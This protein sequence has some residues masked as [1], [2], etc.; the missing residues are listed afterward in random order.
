MTER[1]ERG[2][3]QIGFASMENVVSHSFG[4]FLKMQSLI[5]QQ[6]EI[7]IASVIL[8]CS[9]SQV[10]QPEAGGIQPSTDFW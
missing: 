7:N 4:R 6:K 2:G 10:V 9:H 5:S 8:K 1:N 3:Q